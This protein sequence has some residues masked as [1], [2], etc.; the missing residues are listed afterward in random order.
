MINN[1]SEISQFIS[2]RTDEFEQMLLVALIHNEPLFRQ[3]RPII[4]TRQSDE[5]LFRN[6]VHEAIYRAI[7]AIN[8]MIVDAG[9]AVAV[10][11]IPEA[12]LLQWLNAF[13][14]EGRLISSTEIPQAMQIYAAA[15]R[16]HFTTAAFQIVEAGWR[17]WME[18]RG[19]EQILKRVLRRQDTDVMQEMS[20]LRQMVGK[21]AEE[22][23]MFTFQQ[24]LVAKS[25]HVVRIPTGLPPLDR[26]L[27]GGL[28][29][30]EGTLILGSPNSGKSVASSQF[31]FDM[32]CQGVFHKGLL[33]HTEMDREEF[34]KR[35]I[36]NKCKIPY[37]I[38]MDKSLEEISA[39][40]PGMSAEQ[41]HCFEVLQNDMRVN[42]IIYRWK[43]YSTKTGIFGSIDD[44][45]KR[46]QDAMGGLDHMHLDWLGGALGADVKSDPQKLRLAWRSAADA[47]AELAERHKIVAVAYAQAHPEASKNKRK[48]TPEMASEC[49]SLHVP[50]TTAIGISAI[51][52]PEA[53]GSGP[54]QDETATF[55]KEQWLYLGKSRKSPGGCIQ[56]HRRYDQM[57]MAP[58]QH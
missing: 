40:I 7:E 27:G 16:Q 33:I 29:K 35:I 42:W 58:P 47:C 25:P 37:A 32:S 49:K 34:I 3:V 6:S 55:Q 21:K 19:Q 1:P 23:E 36:S 52:T 11:A 14:A 18:R 10:G 28:G 13:A 26:A 53:D 45:L 5:Q 48:V 38:I 46:A 4:A 39:L 56:F 30:G 17:I 20:D 54:V 24:A 50:M 9:Q 43:D 41:R 2:A 12:L 22:H 8:G 51:R 15:W 57:R 31:S 44:M